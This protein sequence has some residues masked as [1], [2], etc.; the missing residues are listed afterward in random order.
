MPTPATRAAE[1][2]R[3]QLR[4]HRRH[5]ARARASR[6]RASTYGDHA[7]GLDDAGGRIDADDLVEMRE[8]DR[9]APL[10][11]ARS[12]NRFDVVLASPI[13]APPRAPAAGELGDE[14]SRCLSA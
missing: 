6:R 10:A 13:A 8:I 14:L 2:D 7:F 4:H 3:L 11:R 1:R 12:R 5:R 9:A